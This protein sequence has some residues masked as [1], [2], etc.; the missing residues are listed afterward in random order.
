MEMGGQVGGKVLQKGL[1][2]VG[3]VAKPVLGRLSGAGTGAIEEAL[4][5]S[6]PFTDAMRGKITGEEVVSAAQDA[7]QTLRNSRGAA[8]REKLAEIGKSQ[9]EIDVTSINSKL[10]DLMKQFRVKVSPEGE[11]DFSSVAIGNKGRKDIKEMVE[12]V[13]GWKDK[14]PLGIDA[15]KRYLGDFYSESSQARAFTTSITKEVT[16]TLEKQIPQYVEMTKPYAEATKIIK[17]IES[18]LM[19][20]KQGISGRITADQTLRRLTSAM[21]DNFELR[22]DLVNILGEQ[23][24]QD[25]SGLTAGY[26]MSQVLPRGLMGIASVSEAG[27]MLAKVISPKYLPILVASSPRVQ[28]E[29]LRV[30]GKALKET[31]GGSIPFGKM[32][33]YLALR[34][35]QEEKK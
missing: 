31:V 14:T 6:K 27:L 21:R 10:R 30:Y 28:G 11:L 18:G 35:N 29:F 20:R 3:K 32:M 16:N 5:G 34:K 22:R 12:T 33:S 19:M 8:Y 15:L 2:V 23:S 9:N 26:S 25:I 4:K 13:W 17:D 24:G 1:E 7:L